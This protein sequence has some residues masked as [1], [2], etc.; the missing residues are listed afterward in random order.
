MW[1]TNEGNN[2][3]RASRHL[4]PLT[5]GITH[6]FRSEMDNFCTESEHVSACCSY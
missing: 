3:N 2:Q 4:L 1:K 6:T 5:P